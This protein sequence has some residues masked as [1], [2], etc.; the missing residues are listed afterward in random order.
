MDDAVGVRRGGLDGEFEGVEGGA[1]VAARDVGEVGEGGV[2]D[3][4]GAV[5]VA[6][7]RIVEGA[8]E[9][10]D[11]LVCAEG[12]EVEEARAAEQRPN[13][14]KE[15]VCLQA[16]P[17][18]SSTTI[19]SNISHVGQYAAILCSDQVPLASVLCSTARE[20]YS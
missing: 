15:R 14:L 4:D 9:E 3:G 17:P 7:L 2:G 1:S 8:V 18:I 19:S 11:G 13:D 20:V 16:L 6:A 12:F 5:A 10:G